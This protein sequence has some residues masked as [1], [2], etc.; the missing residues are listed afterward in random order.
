MT[1]NITDLRVL[2]GP[3]FPLTPL[4]NQV[5]ALKN[6]LEQVLHLSPRASVSH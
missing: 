1:V 3:H 6:V 2:I 5:D 4:P